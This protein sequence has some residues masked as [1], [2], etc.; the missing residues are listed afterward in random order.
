MGKYSE[1]LVHR[2]EQ[3]LSKLLFGILSTE[4]HFSM[5]T[6]FTVRR[7]WILAATT[8]G[9]TSYT[10]GIRCQWFI[11]AA[12][13]ASLG[14]HKV[15]DVNTCVLLTFKIKKDQL[16][17]APFRCC[18][19]QVAFVFTLDKKVTAF[20]LILFA[21]VLKW[22]SN[23]SCIVGLATETLPISGTHR[24]TIGSIFVV[25]KAGS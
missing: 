6:T 12:R 20:A 5:T 17:R 23:I 9:P 7:F 13:A 14:N 11:D 22:I 3:P 15:G 24:I 2:V 10:F 4:N 1:V 19:G 25:V 21:F 16:V 8:A 18:F